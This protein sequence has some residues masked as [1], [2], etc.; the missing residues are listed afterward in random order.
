MAATQTRPRTSRQV[1]KVRSARKAAKETTREVARQFESTGDA[2]KQLIVSGLKDELAKRV[3][4]AG[5]QVGSFARALETA[6]DQL[7]DDGQEAPA[8]FIRE[9]V[10]RLQDFES[11]LQAK[12]PDTILSDIEDFARKNPWA[13]GLAGAFLGLATSRFVKA[14]ARGSSS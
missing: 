14:S 13:L 2:A 5:D 11:Y 8:D 10:D 4:T 7:Q 3:S 6:A 12:D 1:Q 9:A